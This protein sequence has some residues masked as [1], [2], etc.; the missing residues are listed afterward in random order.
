MVSKMAKLSVLLYH[1]EREDF[2]GKLREVGVVHIE[3]ADKDLNAKS[4]AL[5][6][7]LSE[8]EKVIF[9]IKRASKDISGEQRKCGFGAAEAVKKYI[10]NS[11]RIEAIS[12]EIA[13]ISKEKSRFDPWGDVSLETLAK[14]REKGVYVSLYELPMKDKPLLAN[15]SYEVV[16]E[17]SSHIWIA[18]LGLQEPIII[19]GREPSDLPDITLSELKKKEALLS[20]EKDKLLIEQKSITTCLDEIKK[21]KADVQDLLNFEIASSSLESAAKEKL[22]SI[23]GWVP[24]EKQAELQKTLDSFSCWYEFEEPSAKDN[25]PVKYQNSKFADKYEVITNLFSL[26]KYTEIDPTPFFAPFYMLFFGFCMGDVGYGALVLGL[27]IFAYFKMSVENKLRPIA[28]LA[29]MLGFATII[30]GFLLNG[31][32]GL[33]IFDSADGTGLLGTAGG[34]SAF[35]LL[36]ATQVATETGVK[37]IMPMVPFSL[38]L[39]VFQIMFGM[40]LKIINKLKQNNGDIKYALYPIGTMLLTIAATLVVVQI[41]FLDMGSIF[42]VFFGITAMQIASMIAAPMIIVPLVAGL[43]LL[44]LFNNPS[45]PIGVRLPLGLWELYQYITGIMGDVLSYIRLFALGLAG[46]LLGASFNEIALMLTGGTLSF[47][48]PLVI[49]T[50]L[51]LI[52]GHTINIALAGLAAFVHPLRLTFVEFYKYLEFEGGAREYKPFKKAK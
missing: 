27:A 6:G 37:T 35:S 49:F 40:S 50:I 1:G 18:A 22:L 36:K 3:K 17:T 24:A 31:F 2:L 19:E 45:K 34:L 7:E 16:K 10:A 38:F 12:N 33:P 5:A 47:S 48:T 25:V 21:H 30:G 11:A 42:E 20:S 28:A 26:P 13:A 43:V 23:S 32:F 9:D 52:F 14:L 41:N 15:I 46:G 29:M 44:F 39:G 4:A 8:V 51:V